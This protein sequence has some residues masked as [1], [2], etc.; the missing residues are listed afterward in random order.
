M[1]SL[2]RRCS[3]N[4]LKKFLELENF[5]KLSLKFRQ[6]LLIFFWNFIKFFQNFL[7]INLIFVNS[8]IWYFL[9]RG[10]AFFIIFKNSPKFGYREFVSVIYAK[11]KFDPSSLDCIWRKYLCKV[12]LIYENALIESPFLIN[13]YV[14]SHKI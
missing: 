10:N 4:F 1:P 13:F 9:I 7:K 8:S 3:H 12:S 14:K 2:C 5:L 6:N 11:R